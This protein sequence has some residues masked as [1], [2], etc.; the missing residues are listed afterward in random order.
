MA[1]SNDT[2]TALRWVEGWKRA[3]RRLRELKK[4]DLM[5]VSTEQALWNLAGAFESCRRHFTPRPDS[6]LVE[7]QRW[8]QRLRK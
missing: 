4:S 8:F 3:G 2:T 5:M 7:Q 1:E 6:G